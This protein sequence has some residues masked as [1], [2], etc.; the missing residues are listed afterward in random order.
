MPRLP[1]E[2]PV[3]YLARRTFPDYRHLTGEAR[4][5]GLGDVGGSF[6]PSPSRVAEFEKWMDEHEALPDAELHLLV[7][8][9]K[10]KEAAERARLAELK[11]QQ[12]FFHQAKANAD[13]DFWSKTAHWTIDE[14]IALSLGKSPKVV[15]L[16]RVQPYAAS[17]FDGTLASPFAVEYTQR[18]E[19]AR[20]AIAW[21]QIYDPILPTLFLAWAR[22]LDLPVPAALTSAIEAR[23]LVIA[24]WQSLH[25]QQKE[26]ATGWKKRYDD[27]VASTARLPEA[28]DKVLHRL[29]EALEEIEKLKGRPE[30]EPEVNLSTRERDSLLR[31]VIGMAIGGYAY[32]PK[33]S[34]SDV[35][36]LIA[37][38]LMEQGISM[39]DDTVRK[40]L[41][42]AS[43]NVLP[44]T[45]GPN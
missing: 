20:R 41:K 5:Y 8:V 31:L 12:L 38:D 39:T 34:R 24:D 15:D 30:P 13:F 45:A 17:G 11:E 35:P 29:A 10:Q 36:G 9:E 7:A 18:W 21:K 37:G 2:T 1:I 40:W 16:K 3:E 19:L 43:A 42:E 23:G 33:A 4:A 6:E 14:A 32:D 25:D 28:S 22:R 27:L 26:L 44:K